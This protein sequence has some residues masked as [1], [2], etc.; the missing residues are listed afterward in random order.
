ME[1]ALVIGASGG[2]GGALAAAL[3][4]LLANPEQ[5]RQLGKAGRRRVCSRYS[6]DRVAA[7]TLLS[8]ADLLPLP[9]EQLLEEEVPS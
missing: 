9:L 2:I 1:R 8:Y 4:E 7:Q 6:W 5:A 3:A